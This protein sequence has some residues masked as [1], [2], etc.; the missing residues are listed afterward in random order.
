ME[1]QQVRCDAPH[2]EDPCFRNILYHH[3]IDTVQYNAVKQYAG[4]W[5]PNLQSE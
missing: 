1:A 4:G 3:H 5:I 2:I